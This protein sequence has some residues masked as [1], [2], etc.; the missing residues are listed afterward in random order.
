MDTYQPKY[1]KMWRHPN[2][3]MGATWE[4]Y[5]VV[6]GQHRDSD[7]ITRSNF[8]V[9]HEELDRIFDS[10]A[11]TLPDLPNDESYII[12]PYES[13]WAVGHVEWIGLHKDSPAELLECA[14]NLLKRIDS[15][16]ILDEHHES[17]LEWTEVSEYWASLS[18]RA[19]LQDYIE[20]AGLSCFAA[21]HDIGTIM[22][23]YDADR[24][25]ESLT[26]E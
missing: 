10:L 24:L 18:I 17:D 25:W 26:S 6:L 9:A 4:N 14:D 16:P 23:N 13:H 2:S 7:R 22:H 20:P 11:T 19:R 12:N 15:Y 8:V 5:Y 3:Y 1:L 21:R